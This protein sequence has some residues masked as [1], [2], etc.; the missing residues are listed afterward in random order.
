MVC[1]LS[2]LLEDGLEAAKSIFKWKKISS[3]IY[4]ESQAS[5]SS[6]RDSSVLT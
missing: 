6:S 3:F 2:L 5:F 1:C 4:E